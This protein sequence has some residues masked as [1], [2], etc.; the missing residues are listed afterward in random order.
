ME[1][2]RKECVWED[3]NECHRKN[4]VC[5]ARVSDRIE[6]LERELNEER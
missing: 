6:Q 4:Y 5:T 2:Y 3:G 1:C